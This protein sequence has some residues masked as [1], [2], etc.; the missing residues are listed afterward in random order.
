M[1]LNTLVRATEPTFLFFQSSGGL[2]KMKPKLTT[3]PR[4][5]KHVVCRF[6]SIASAIQRYLARPSVPAIE[7]A[8]AV[9][10]GGPRP[11]E[12]AAVA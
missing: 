8:Q 9:P 12:Q 2:G 5:F 10:I 11:A 6:N 1:T 4:I 3:L 7:M